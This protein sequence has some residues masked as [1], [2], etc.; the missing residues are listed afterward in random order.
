[1]ISIWL[2]VSNAFRH[3]YRLPFLYDTTVV[4]NNGLNNGLRILNLE[5]GYL[6]D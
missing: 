3:L 6:I 4:S 2:T 1:M 5:T